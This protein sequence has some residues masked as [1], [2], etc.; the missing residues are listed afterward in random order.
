MKDAK[1]ESSLCPMRFLSFDETASEQTPCVE[2]TA[3]KLY[4][5][6]NTRTLSS[7]DRKDLSLYWME[8]LN[9]HLSDID[10][11]EVQGDKSEQS[12]FS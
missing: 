8:H 12:G 2:C 10:L 1:A 4:E 7:Q 6:A 9:S 5:K 3:L 11:N